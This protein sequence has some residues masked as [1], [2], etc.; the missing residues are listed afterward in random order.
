MLPLIAGAT[1]YLRQRDTDRRVGPSFLTD[2]FTWLAFFAITAVAVYS[3]YRPRAEGLL[4]TGVAST[5]DE[6]LRLGLNPGSDARTR[7]G[8]RQSTAG[9]TPRTA[10]RDP[11]P[12][13]RPATSRSASPSWLLVLLVLFG[14][15]VSYEQSIKSFF[16]DDDPDM[17]AYQK[18]A[19]VVRRRQLRLRRLRRPRAAD[20]GRDGPGRRAGRG[21]RARRRSTGVLRVE[22]LDAMP[23]LWKID[24][25]LLAARPAPRL[26]PQPAR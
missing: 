14:K 5:P 3:V 12:A 17:A 25:A 8:L 19:K 16:A 10:H 6:R 15:R 20:P 9:A 24:D 11:P 23:L 2:I 21:G 1:L 7:R 4:V 26:R 13:A 22:S 18:A